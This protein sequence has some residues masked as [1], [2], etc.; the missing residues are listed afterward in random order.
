MVRSAGILIAVLAACTAARSIVAA[1]QI[2]EFGPLALAPGQTVAL[3]L[4]GQ[5]LLDVRELWTSFASRCD[6]APP[7]GESA[8]KGETLE[9]RVTVPRDEQVGVGAMRIVTG[10]GVSNPVLVMLDDLPTVAETADN[11]ARDSAQPVDWPAAVDGRCEPLEEDWFRFHAAAGQRLSFEV[12]SQRL[13]ARLDPTLRLS[14]ADGKELARVDDAADVGG[15]SRLSHLF[16]AEGDYVLAVGDVRHVGGGA[17]FRYR[18]RIG[19]F[20]IIRGVYPAGARSGS[21]ASFEL[22][23]EGAEAASLLHVALPAADD[24]SRLVSYGVPSGDRRGSGWFQVEA[25]P[26]SEALEQEPNETIAEATPATLPGALN[27]RF[28]QAGDRDCFK[29]HAAKGQRLY[30][31]AKTR[32]LGSPCDVYMS[33]HKAD[34]ALLSVAR[35]ERETILDAEIPEEGDYALQVEDLIGGA[36]PDHVYRIDASDAFGGFSLHAEQTQYS[37]PQGGTFVMKVLA[38]RRAYGGPI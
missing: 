5:N 18:L 20:P 6:F 28:G 25:S 34:G 35:Q 4:R 15:D 22:R 11:H 3:T 14:T 32:E 8:A 17:E 23:D 7:Q 12:V 2:A 9:C 27:G 24:Q 26:L 31:V 38:Q 16:E 29:F 37:A 19:A 33:L 10:E 1:P 13:G 21:V 30:C 36:G